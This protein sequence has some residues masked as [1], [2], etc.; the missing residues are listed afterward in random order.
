[1]YGNVVVAYDASDGARAAL[2]R[3][4]AIAGR[5]GA[6]LTVV[7]AVP[8]KLPALVPGAPSATDAQKAAETRRELRAAVDA[9]D[10]KLQASPWAVGGPAAKAILV[11]AEDIEA[12]LIVTGSRRRGRVATAALGSVSAEI[13]HGAHCD[14]LVT[15]PRET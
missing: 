9:L 12:D 1:M 6:A 13:V 14:V 3:A 15:H 11:V 8:E 4:V 5:D 7:E 10:P 2:E